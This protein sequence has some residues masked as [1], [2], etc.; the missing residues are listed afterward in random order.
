MMVT[1]EEFQEIGKKYGL[2]IYES[3][4]GLYLAYVKDGISVSVYDIENK[5]VTVSTK[6][7][8]GKA[9]DT[10]VVNDIEELENELQTTL[11]NLKLYKIRQKMERIDEDF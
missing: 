6:F 10:K 9:D 11:K 3:I 2:V 7:F 5:T 4:F 1:I 8:V